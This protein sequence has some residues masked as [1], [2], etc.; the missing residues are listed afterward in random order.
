MEKN[1]KTQTKKILINVDFEGDFVN[2][3]GVL[4]VP[5]AEKLI[6]R[7][8]DKINDESYTDII[9]T[10]DTHEKDEYDNSEE[11]KLFPFHCG[12]KTEGWQLY[13]ITP[14]NNDKFQETINETDKPFEMIK[15]ENEYFFTKNVFDIWEGN[16]IFEKWFTETYPK[17][18]IIEVVGVATNYCVFM[19]VMGLIK[20]GYQVR[21]I[22]DCVAGIQS[23]PDGT[24]D[25]SYAN[26]II[27]MVE[28]NVCFTQ[29][30]IPLEAIVK[31]ISRDYFID[32][33]KAQ[34]IIDNMRNNIK[35]YVEKNNIKSLVMGISGGLDSAVVAA[36]CQEKYI[37]IP[38]I[39]LSIPMSNTNT[40]REFA[41][42]VGETYCTEFEEFD[43]WD[44][45]FKNTG[46]VIDIPAYQDI[47]YRLERTDGIAQKAGF[48]VEKFPKSV[49]QGNMKA[50]IRMFT[51]YDLARK[52][53]G[54][55]LSTDNYSE[56]L[57]GFWTICG[58]VGDYGPIQKIFKG[59]ELPYIAKAL[60]IRE[61]IIT[62]K[63]S[64]GLMVTEDNTDEAQ[65][66][67]NY[68]TVD[69]IMCCYMYDKYYN[70]FKVIQDLDVV[71]NIIKRYQNTE[72]KRNGGIVLER[73]EIGIEL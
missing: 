5:G 4:Y 64:D 65:L 11:K 1:M 72:F 16:N 52:T 37:G 23:F 63:P 41:K 3:N 12:Y 66:G 67:A 21:I 54:M 8:Q 17:D 46:D 38:L 44:E 53:N 60:E 33:T 50:R 20:R 2:P 47:F 7:I 35:E 19:N 25:E 15:I 56:L 59:L 42:W 18:T 62:Q 43:A 34:N 10:F 36:I 28:N 57:M 22:D 51:L 55:V 45:P 13:G 27:T 9:Y 31:K 14:R 40:H 30:I 61:D 70:Y 69:T 68:P 24:I 58:D 26:N 6:S 49:L 39:G 29:N 71:K 73:N 48:K 32:E